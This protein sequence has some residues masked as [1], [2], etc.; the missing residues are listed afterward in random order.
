MALLVSGFTI[1]SVVVFAHA[2]S[3]YDEPKWSLGRKEYLRLNATLAVAGFFVIG[4]L[5]SATAWFF[6]DLGYQI[7][8]A[9]FAAIAVSPD[10]LGLAVFNGIVACVMYGES[11]RVRDDSLASTTNFITFLV[12]FVTFL[13]YLAAWLVAGAEEAESARRF[14][15]HA[16]AGSGVWLAVQL[17]VLYTR[18]FLCDSTRMYVYFAFLIWCS[19]GTRH[20]L[21]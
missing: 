15:S 17:Y 9:A 8:F 4:A 10:A 16:M 3:H 21:F 11:V 12:F 14:A 6:E 13:S 18:P 2:L 19:V 1:A 5:S 20:L 7:A